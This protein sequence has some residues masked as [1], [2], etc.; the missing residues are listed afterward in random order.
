MH[1]LK[2]VSIKN[3]FDFGPDTVDKKNLCKQCE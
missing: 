3:V 2:T 1:V